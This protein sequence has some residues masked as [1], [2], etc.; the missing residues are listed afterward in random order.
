MRAVFD[1]M[2]D[3]QIELAANWKMFVVHIASVI[4]PDCLST[5]SIFV[6]QLW[7][8]SIATQ[9]WGSENMEIFMSAPLTLPIVSAISSAT[10][11]NC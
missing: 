1:P 6:S 9:K 2:V 3:L 8:V 7:L 4:L 5:I 11:L 10:A